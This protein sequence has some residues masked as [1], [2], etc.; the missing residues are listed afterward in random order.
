MFKRKFQ[1]GKE[2][3]DRD[4]FEN[5]VEI[6]YDP[7]KLKVI[8]ESIE[9]DGLWEE[10]FEWRISTVME[11]RIEIVEKKNKK[12]FRVTVKCDYEFRCHTQ[13]IERAVYFATLYSRMIRDMWHI[14]G[15]AS[16][17]PEKVKSGQII[18]KQHNPRS[19]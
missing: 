14:Y 18:W 19:T 17:A 9:K 6:T 12:W 13:T 11:S 3:P 5:L 15:W 4:Y 8:K 7:S 10:L 2:S 1:K 16:S